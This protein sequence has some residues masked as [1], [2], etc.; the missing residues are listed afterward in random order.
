MEP[1]DASVTKRYER[2]D[3]I[4]NKLPNRFT[5]LTS[6]SE[7]LKS[8][9]KPRPKSLKIGSE[10]P[11]P[12]ARIREAALSIAGLLSENRYQDLE[13]MSE[14]DYRVPA[15]GI[16]NQVERYPGRIRRP[17]PQEVQYYVYESEEPGVYVVDS[18]VFTEEEGPSELTAVFKLIERDGV[19][20]VYFRDLLIL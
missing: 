17:S 19:C 16:K 13:D 6:T 1:R 9:R 18:V 7:V 2:L 4:R 11:I 15:S 5:E 10:V 8:H 20:E 3:L 14:P 12:D